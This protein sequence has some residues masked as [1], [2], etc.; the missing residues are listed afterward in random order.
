MKR[1]RSTAD[2]IDFLP[3]TEPDQNTA[4]IEW[5]PHYKIMSTDDNQTDDFEDDEDV[6]QLEE[7][8][9]FLKTQDS[10][11]TTDH[12]TDTES[13]MTAKYICAGLTAIIL[14]SIYM[15]NEQIGLDIITM[16]L[17]LVSIVY[18]WTNG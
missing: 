13:L 1:P 7:I 14:A 6:E 8:R 9:E 17:S 12:P 4:I 18:V 3:R 5:W 2:F 16:I 15:W 10:K 11:D